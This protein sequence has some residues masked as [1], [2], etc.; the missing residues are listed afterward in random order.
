M[1]RGLDWEGI[2]VGLVAVDQAEFEV[3]QFEVLELLSELAG[4]L[5]GGDLGMLGEVPGEA[6]A[7]VLEE[8]DG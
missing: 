7:K 1:G 4:P 5:Y 3:F 8:V 2:V 6:E